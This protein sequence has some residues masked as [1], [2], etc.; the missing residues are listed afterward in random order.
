MSKKQPLPK[1]PL[2]GQE[3]APPPGDAP[4]LRI[5]DV[6]LSEPP[7]AV[8][9]PPPPPASTMQDVMAQLFGES[10]V[11]PPKPI[12]VVEPLPA[13]PAPPPV[14]SQEMALIVTY[15][16]HELPYPTLKAE[17]YAPPRPT[18]RYS[19]MRCIVPSCNR[20]M[21]T[22]NQDKENLCSDCG[23]VLRETYHSDRI[24]HE[25][26]QRSGEIDPFR[27]YGDT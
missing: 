20:F 23:Y 15:A 7:P 5:E 18:D 11:P 19:Q 26:S 13:G 16:R 22:R 27:D 14:L 4:G 2:K 17:E 8:V 9:V 1:V 25:N 12:V 10:P 21:W 3:L 6:E 24:Q